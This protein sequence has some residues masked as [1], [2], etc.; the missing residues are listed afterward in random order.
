MNFIQKL[1]YAAFIICAAAACF[2]V[3]FA[4]NL[5]SIMCLILGIAGFAR[6]C[7]Y[8]PNFNKDYHEW[9]INSPWKGEKL[10]AGPA[11]LVYKDAIILIGLTLI[12]FFCLPVKLAYWPVIVFLVFYNVGILIT[13]NINAVFL[14][15]ILAPFYY[16]SD[17]NLIF[18]ISGILLIT[19]VYQ[20]LYLQDRKDLFLNKKPKFQKDP[21]YKENPLLPNAKFE[22]RTRLEKLLLIAT[23]CS[24]SIALPKFLT[25]IGINSPYRSILILGLLISAIKLSTSAKYGSCSGFIY[26][27]KHFVLWDY[28][29]D[30]IF[31]IPLTIAG[32]GFLLAE[33]SL[34][35]HIPSIV[36]FPLAT[37]VL[38]TIGFFC[39]PSPKEWAL[40]GKLV[41]YK[42]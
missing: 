21:N 12:S 5:S 37:L 42:P 26:R 40:T 13:L 18:F 16:L 1:I 32:T 29:F 4:E 9:L 23:A 41:L 33:L 22:E 34:L 28:K 25:E 24:F 7:I 11:Q 35:L 20:Y 17:G 30:R 14:P 3:E 6:V 19:A 15:V 2:L 31:F 36:A 8:H 10:P 39:G 38:T 27:L